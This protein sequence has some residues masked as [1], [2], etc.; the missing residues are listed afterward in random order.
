MKKIDIVE[1]LLET[2]DAGGSAVL[3]IVVAVEGSAPRGAGAWMAVLEDGSLAGTVGGGA[4]EARVVE[5]ARALLAAGQSRLVRY[6]IGGPGSDTGMVCGGAVDLLLMSVTAGHCSTLLGVR[7]ALTSRDEA[8]LVID[9]D[10]FGGPLPRGEHGEKA[11]RTID[12]APA[13]T[14]ESL[15]DQT[16]LKAGILVSDERRCRS[17]DPCARH[18]GNAG[19]RGSDAHS[20]NRD[21]G[22]EV[23]DAAARAARGA[24][25]VEP[26]RPEA[27]VFVFGCGHVGRALVEVLGFAGF[28]VVACDN[29]PEMLEPELLP[30]TAARLLVDY[31]DLAASLTVGPRDFV[32]VCTAGHGS[33][34][35]V[36]C[37]TL[38]RR[39]AYVG[40]LGSRKKTA[41]TK[42]RLLD[43]GFSSEDV[44]AVRMPVGV[45]IA[46]ETPEEIAISIAAQ[47]VDAR[48]RAR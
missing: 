45:P 17:V 27:R 43:A 18:F 34:F 41:H 35:E 46:C 32:V 37:Q 30:R 28:D 6:T 14:L 9:L 19:P 10:P 2:L 25:Y 3:A 47:L 48:R 4:L 12:G 22:C 36:L 1:R 31:D 15:A 23:G 8:A 5:D 24:R 42:V 44:D 16:A 40:C 21:M 26:L 11:A 38:S 39:P 33:D 7:Q 20:A 29:R 13:L